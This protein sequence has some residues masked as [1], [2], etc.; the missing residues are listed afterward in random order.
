MAAGRKCIRP[1][2]GGLALM[3][4]L[5]CLVLAPAAP[6]PGKPLPERP[7]FYFSYLEF[8]K[9]INGQ[10]S[11]TFELVSPENAK[12]IHLLFREGEAPNLYT[13]KPVNGIIKITGSHRRLVRVY[14]FGRAGDRILTASAVF[15]LWGNSKTP[16]ER[17]PAGQDA[18]AAL[19]AL[20]FVALSPDRGG[21][22]PQTGQAFRFRLR[23]GGPDSSETTPEGGFKVVERETLRPLPPDGTHIPAHDL[24]LNR[25]GAAAFRQDIVFTDLI[26]TDRVGGGQR[27]RASYTLKLHRSR[28]AQDNHMAGWAAMGGS[29][30]LF[31]G[32]V[33]IKRRRPWWND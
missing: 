4:A 8:K 16:A 27:V 20:P 29:L 21:Y 10:A 30:C 23:Q 6:A 26:F 15:F 32:W 28:T 11:Q 33:L 22:W 9:E 2:R 17:I 19:A 14:A 18:R 13:I 1:C 12:G 5:L 24:D 25:Q 3:A 31:T 7:E